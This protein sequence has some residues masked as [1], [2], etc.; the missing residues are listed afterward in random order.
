MG[1]AVRCVVAICRG[2][3]ARTGN[4]GSGNARYDS[5]D[6]GRGKGAQR[7]VT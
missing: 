6:G 1:R 4:R 7:L 2:K 3:K 5:R